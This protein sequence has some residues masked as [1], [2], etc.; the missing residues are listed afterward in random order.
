MRAFIVY[1]MVIFGGFSS[2]IPILNVLL[3]FFPVD[4]C[5]KVFVILGSIYF[6]EGM[7]LFGV[8]RRHKVPAV[9]FASAWV[10][11]VIV[12]SRNTDLKGQVHFTAILI[13][14]EE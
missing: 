13:H 2:K 8:V 4:C 9:G 7:R 1:I 14:A 10:C 3:C 6:H 12:K 5:D 11:Q